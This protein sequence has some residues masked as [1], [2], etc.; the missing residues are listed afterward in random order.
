MDNTHALMQ[1]L[2]EFFKQHPSWPIRHDDQ[3]LQQAIT[4]KS[5]SA[6]AP[7]EDRPCN[8]RLEFL[9]D[10]V[11]GMIVAHQLFVDYP[12]EAE[13]ILTLKKIY[14]VK[15]PTLADAARAIHLGQWLLLGKGEEKSGGRDKDVVLADMM[16]SLI[17]YLWIQGWW[18]TVHT[19]V[20]N[21]IYPRRFDDDAERGKSYK[22]LLQERI[23]QHYQQLPTY[24]D[25]S[26][27][28]ERSGNILSFRS[29]IFLNDRLL[30]EWIE[31]NKKKAQELAAERAYK[32]LIHQDL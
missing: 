21:T 31:S 22:S 15:E 4:H 16:E 12:E 27:E 3:L 19:F 28:V 9:G 17:A 24:I 32:L 23:Q 7:Q 18:E 25:E 30:A 20:T 8:E 10:A 6:D 13:S 2:D 5:Y 1:R 26:Y 29:Q 14:L 11:L